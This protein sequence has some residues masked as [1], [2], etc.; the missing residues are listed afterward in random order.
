[1]V[2]HVLC[3]SEWNGKANERRWGAGCSLLMAAS[4]TSGTILQRSAICLK[5]K[6]KRTADG[7]Y[8]MQ[9]CIMYLQ[10]ERA[11]DPSW[12]R[13]GWWSSAE[14][15]RCPGYA[16]MCP[17]GKHREREQGGKAEWQRGIK[18]KMVRLPKVETHMKTHTEAQQLPSC[19]SSVNSGIMLMLLP[20]MSLNFCYEELWKLK[21]LFVTRT[22]PTWTLHTV[23]TRSKGSI[24]V[25]KG[26]LIKWNKKENNV[27]WIWNLKTIHFSENEPDQ[28]VQLIIFRVDIWSTKGSW[29]MNVDFLS[30]SCRG[31]SLWSR[32][33]VMFLSSFCPEEN[34][35][36]TMYLTICPSLCLCLCAQTFPESNHCYLSSVWPSAVRDDEWHINWSW[37]SVCL[38]SLYTGSVWMLKKVFLI[39]YL[40][41]F[42]FGCFIHWKEN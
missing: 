20:E 5:M 4:E 31:L 27:F 9:S 1:M 29:H 42:I 18:Q 22:H 8:C 36:D 15:R 26:C 40:F 6:V 39:I 35:G 13:S 23:K 38:E 16:E 25:L 2:V 33:P 14:T 19:C 21:V 10:S 12:W 34:K 3:V 11:H 17:P 37:T 41:I 7:A 30:Y 24:F 32:F 28:N